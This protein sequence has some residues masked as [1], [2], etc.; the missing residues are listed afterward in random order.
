MGEIETGKIEEKIEEKTEEKIEEKAEEVIYEVT[1]EDVE[2]YSRGLFMSK[3]FKTIL[4][5]GAVVLV[6]ALIYG[7][8]NRSAG[9]SGYDVITSIDK[10]DNLAVN[11][12]VTEKGIIRYSKDGAS[13]TTDLKEIEWNQAFEIGNGKVVS[14]EDFMAIGDI[15]SNSIRIFNSNGQVGALTTMTPIVD[16]AV[17][18]QGVVYAVLSNNNENYI[19]SYDSAGNALTSIKASIDKTGYPLRIALSNDGT[20]LLVGYLVFSDKGVST[21]LIFYNFSDAGKSEID[22]IVGEYDYDEIFGQ[23]AFIDNDTIV[24]YGEKRVLIISMRSKPQILTEVALESEIKSI[25][26]NDEYIGF[27]ISNEKDEESDDAYKLVIYTASGREY[28]DATF[29]YGYDKISCSGTEILLYNSGS[30]CIYD[31]HANEKFSYEFDEPIEALMPSASRGRYI[32][33]TEDKISEITF[34]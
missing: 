26:Y 34:R 17:A 9:Y 20:K 24:A 18:R 21:R 25:F 16:L 6:I 30:C 10:N 33:V 11:Y 12:Q 5:V 3:R 15:G 1:E 2:R 8:A 13:F 29:D 22:N 32:L 7:L 23:L 19:D 4:I 27:V 28:A 14:C 31:W